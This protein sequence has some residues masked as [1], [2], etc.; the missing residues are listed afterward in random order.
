MFISNT[1]MYNHSHSKIRRML[2]WVVMLKKP[3]LSTA[4]TSWQPNWSSQAELTLFERFG[5]YNQ[6][7]SRGT[8]LLLYR[9]P[10][11]YFNNVYSTSPEQSTSGAW[12]LSSPIW[13]R[14]P[15]CWWRIHVQ[16]FASVMSILYNSGGVHTHIRIVRWLLV[17]H[18]IPP[19][20]IWRL[21]I[22]LMSMPITAQALI[23][24]F[25]IAS[26]FSLAIL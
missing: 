10:L 1:N 26:Q 13:N 18:R 7:T 16:V 5:E 14:K 2:T 9:E 8:S 17:L 6:P 11:S 3:R 12:N 24:I 21:K 22:H 20:R 15:L 23:Q 19:A 4:K 25:K